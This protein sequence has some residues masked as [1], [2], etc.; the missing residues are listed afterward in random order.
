MGHPLESDDVQ[1]HVHQRI[2]ERGVVRLKDIVSQIF[3]DPRKL[4]SYA[5]DLES[6]RG[7]D[8]AIAFQKYLGFTRENYQLLLKQVQDK[9]MDAEAVPTVLDEIWTAV[10]SRCVHN[11]SKSLTTDQ[12]IVVWKNTAKS[13]VPLADRLVEMMEKLPQERQEQVLNFARS[14]YKTPA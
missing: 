13:W 3:I 9:V 6:L 4:T 2:V 7:R 5:L 14:L 8:K 12:F 10:S 1:S 11:R